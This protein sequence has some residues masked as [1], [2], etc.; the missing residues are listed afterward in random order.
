MQYHHAQTEKKKEKKTNND[1]T[2]S[3]YP[4]VP[5]LHLPLLPVSRS[6]ISEGF[7]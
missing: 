3:V 6:N 1:F 5:T 7:F 2:L 4:S